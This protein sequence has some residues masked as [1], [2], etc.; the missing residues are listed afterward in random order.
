MVRWGFCAGGCRRCAICRAIFGANVDSIFD[1]TDNSAFDSA[2]GGAFH[3]VF[4]WTD[5]SSIIHDPLF[6]QVFCFVDA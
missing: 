2:L 3:A 5:Q 6:V 1:S 4:L